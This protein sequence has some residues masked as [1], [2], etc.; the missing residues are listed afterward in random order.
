MCNLG[1]EFLKGM[2]CLVVMVVVCV[3][4]GLLVMGMMFDLCNI[5]DDLMING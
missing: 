4:L 3:I 5:L 1:K 2:L